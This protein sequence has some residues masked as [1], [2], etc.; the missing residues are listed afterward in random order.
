MHSGLFA[1]A[2]NR[3]RFMWV[4]KF[5]YPTREEGI[6]LSF[7]F[8]VNNGHRYKAVFSQQC[9]K[10]YDAILTWLMNVRE[11]FKPIDA[12]TPSPL[13]DGTQPKKANFYGVVYM[14]SNPAHFEMDWW[15][16]SNRTKVAK[17][18]IITDLKYDPRI[19]PT[20]I[21]G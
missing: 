7:E 6:C 9:A 2:R 3:Y 17:R 8:E 10:A 15:V 16:D 21:R 12:N 1:V 11:S 18:S 19:D 13:F 5:T 14:P 4:Y 20:V